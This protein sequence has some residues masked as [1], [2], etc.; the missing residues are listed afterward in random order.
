MADSS[1]EDEGIN[2]KNYDYWIIG[3]LLTLV[4]TFTT[5]L[6]VN[7]QKLAHT[8]FPDQRYKNPTWVIGLVLNIFGGLIDVGS[9]AFA[10]QSL[11]AP[12]AS[13]SIVFNIIFSKVMHKKPFHIKTIL[14][15]I[16]LIVGATLT[17]IAGPKG[18]DIESSSDILK[19]FI[20]ISTIIYIIIII[21][22]LIVLYNVTK[23][24]DIM[25]SNVEV[26]GIKF[27]LL[28]RLLYPVM[29]GIIGSFA[30]LFGKSV[31]K[32]FLF[33]I[34]DK[35]YINFLYIFIFAVGVVLTTYFN[36]KWLNKG[37]K[38]FETAHVYPIK[39]ATWIIC[40]MIGGLVV[41][42]EHEEFEDGD[43]YRIV[44]FIFGMI[45]IFFGIIVLSFIKIDVDVSVETSVE[46][47]NQNI[48][49]IQDL[50]NFEELDDNDEGTEIDI[51]IN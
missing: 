7:L 17:I 39:K 41:Y 26:Y 1:E 18:E 33:M 14:S 8:R 16:I 44:L 21:L 47:S 10:P 24:L 37:L 4:A 36:I 23:K 48:I 34:E 5:N 40:S 11:I 46:T 28:H 50:N 27:R 13:S 3:L 51:D 45:I 30:L 2:L 35:E 15:S 43:N 20:S 9:L 12:V 19:F 32:L 38:R 6:G 29:S 49:N 42:R 31:S 22:I 25:E